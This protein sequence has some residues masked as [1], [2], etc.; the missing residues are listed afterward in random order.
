[1]WRRAGLALLASTAVLPSVF[2][3]SLLQTDGFND[4]GGDGSIKVNKLDISFNKGSNEVTFDVS[5]TSEKS[6]EVTASLVVTAYGVKVFE[7]D[8]DPCDGSTKVE[9]LCPRNSSPSALFASSY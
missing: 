7:Q 3:Q 5:G 2:A 9:Q 8:F 6:Q 1:M 4:C